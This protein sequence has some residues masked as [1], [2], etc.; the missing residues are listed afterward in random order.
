MTR[1]ET[2]A[3]AAVNKVL[4]G[5][6]AGHGLAARFTPD[7]HAT[8]G[9]GIEIYGPETGLRSVVHVS[10]EIPDISVNVATYE[11]SDLGDGLST[12]TFRGIAFGTMHETV[13]PEFEADVDR[14][15]RANLASFE[16]VPGVGVGTHPLTKA[17]VEAARPAVEAYNAA[18]SPGEAVRMDLNVFGQAADE[19]DVVCLM[20]PDGTAM[21]IALH[22]GYGEVFVCN[23][24]DNE[25]VERVRVDRKAGLAALPEA[26]RSALDGLDATYAPAP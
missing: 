10:V 2:E 8:M 13:T 7:S 12:H 26:L 25:L 18:R 4:K 22:T 5:L 21:A 23:V 14:T 6:P 24:D 1:H 17:M 19:N 11:T 16:P 3:L 9:P 15:L 20:R